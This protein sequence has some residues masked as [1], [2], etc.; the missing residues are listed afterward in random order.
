MNAPDRRDPEVEDSERSVVP[1]LNEQVNRGQRFVR[2]KS[3]LFY[4]ASLRVVARTVFAPQATASAVKPIIADIARRAYAKFC[5]DDGWPI[6]SHIALSSLTSIFSFL[7]FVTALAGFLGTKDIA[8]EATKILLDTWPEPI[9]KPLT[10]EIHRVLTQPHG[11]LLGV[12]AV[13][14][15]YYAS[16]GVEALRIGLN[17]AYDERETRVWW[18]LR[19][20]SIFFVVVGAAAI[21]VFTTFLVLGHVSWAK[22]R[23]Y[24]PFLVTS[25]QFI[26]IPIRYGVS[27]LTFLATLILVH[28]FLPSGQ[29]SFRAI[30]PGVFFTLAVW[31]A[32][33]LAFS[34]Y[35]AGWNTNFSST[36]AGLA[37]IVILLIFLD[38]FGAIFVFGAELNRILAKRSRHE[39]V[40]RRL[41]GSNG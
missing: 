23:D 26:S 40:T 37:S 9:A 28:K 41:S 19:L 2:L 15:I 17:R 32:F 5:V 20:E 14:S 29:R 31:I 33:G 6:A 22:A 13:L 25:L 18:V 35:L 24:A 38:F 10:T 34:I 1:K 36:Y 8:D 39:D 21:T 12:S 11:G 4:R 27:T 3:L 7:I 30:A 16:T